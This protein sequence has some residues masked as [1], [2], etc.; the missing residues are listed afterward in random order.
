M[1]DRNGATLWS[2]GRPQRG[3]EWVE[4]DLG[5]VAPIA[6]VRW[7]P[8]TFQEVPRGLRLESS[9]DGSA[10]R[11]LVDLP[12]Y[13]GPLYWSA[14]RPLLRVRSGRVELRVAPAPVR[15]LRI[16][17]TGRGGVW[18]WTIRELYVYAATG[19]AAA[20]PAGPDGAT[21][22]RAVRSAGIGRLYAD[23][24]WASRIALADPAIRV[25]PANLQ[26]DDYGWKGSASMLL[27][28]FH[29][30]PGT[31]VLLEPTDAES[32]AVAARAGGLP[33][34]RRAVGGLA[35]FVHAPPPSPGARVP[36]GEIQVT[37]SRQLEG[38]GAGDGRGSGH[39][40]GHGRPARGGGLVP[41]RPVRPPD[42]FAAFGSPRPTRPTSPQRLV[43]ESSLDGAHWEILPATLRPEHRFRWAGIG[44]LDDGVVALRARLPA[45]EREG[46]APRAAGGRPAVRLVDQ[47]ARR[48][49]RVTRVP[50][51]PSGRSRPRIAG[52]GPPPGART[53]AGVVA[54]SGDPLIYSAHAH[55]RH[56]RHRVH[57]QPSRP[58][59]SRRG[60]TRCASSTPRP[61]CSTTSSG[62]SG[63]RSPSAA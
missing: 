18:A 5:A 39:A 27:P 30:T 3:G 40:L 48:L 24:G 4:V 45:G 51:G 20:A 55:A 53:G 23:H 42:R 7:L 9:V 61:G 32:F 35:L 11:T 25:P 56:R 1:T 14:G 19:G 60:A 15:Y 34:S 54:A 29:W 49:R 6:L 28:P 62:A 31:G 47:R 50:A 41:P 46:A 52:R 59:P 38:G 16:T 26:L 12:E 2:T 17:Q 21:L 36:A 37:A 43:V 22:A 33:F 58:A 63:R 8:G 13:G 10:W 57:R 44:I